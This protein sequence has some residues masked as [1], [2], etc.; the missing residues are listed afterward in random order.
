MPPI[1]A[2]TDESDR[3]IDAVMF[4]LA[5]VSLWLEDFS[6]VRAVLESWR[7]EGVEDLGDHLR[8]D[9]ERVARCT[10]AIRILKVNARTLALFEATDTDE[11]VTRSGEIFRDDMLATHIDEL[12]HLWSGATSWGG[13]TVNYTLGGRRLDI[14]LEATILPGHE[15][16]WDRVLFAVVDV[17]ERESAHRRAAESEDFARGLFE[18]SPVSLWVEDFGAIKTLL[19]ELRQRGIED[20][21]VFTDVHP[22]FVDRCMTEIRVVDVNRHTLK[23]FGA[24]DKRSL[25]NRTGDV[26][27]DDMRPHFREQLIDLWNGR[28]FQQREVVNYALDGT[29]LA[30]HMQFSVLPGHEDDWKLVQVALTDITARKKAEAYLEYLGKH[31]AL[32]KL[33]NRSFYGEELNRLERDTRLPVAIIIADLNGLKAANDDLGHG[34]GDALLR[35]AGEVLAE[36]V[37]KPAHACRI[38]GDEF[39]VL[40]PAADQR[41]GEAMVDKIR[42]LVALNNQFYSGQELS[43]SIGLAVRGPGERLEEVVKRADALMYAAKRSHYSGLAFDRRRN[44]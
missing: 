30:V 9:P 33:F 22:E 32:T 28:L 6:G 40:M 41:D 26:F 21:R 13:R 17:T 38:G 3:S 43:L 37:E 16:T 7:A 8:E 18:H 44:G 4:D 15:A 31:D 11:I 2:T 39:A 35:R 10:G 20:L 29:A 19:D 42:K 14:E 5:P 1:A 27:R 36:A 34:V 23:L 25:L 12:V 24:R